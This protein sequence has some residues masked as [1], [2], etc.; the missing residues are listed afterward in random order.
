MERGALTESLSETLALFDESGEPRTTTELA[1]ELDLGRR[2]TYDRLERLVDRGRLRTKKVGANARVWW[3]GRN[4]AGFAEPD[5]PLAAESLID[6]VLDG[7]AVGIFVLDENFDVAW[8]NE[9]T[10]RYFGLDRSNVI[11]RDKRTLVEDTIA[12]A[13]EDGDAFAD[14]VLATY[15][16]NVDTEHF[17]C[18]VEG[19]GE[20]AER[21][22]E[23]RS[24]PIESGA[25]AGGRVELYYD[26][27]ERVESERSHR[28]DREEFE[29][30]VDAVDEY[31]IYTM[32]PDG[33]IRTWNP[34]IRRIKGYEAEEVVGE[35]FSMF[36]TEPDREGRVPERNLAMAARNGSY[37]ETG[38][39]VRAD[40][41][42]FWADVTITPIRTEDGDLEGF[43]KVTRD[44]TDYRERE[45][46]LRGERDFNRQILET[47]PASI[48]VLDGEGDVVV[49]NDRF[50]EQ[51]GVTDPAAELSIGDL[52]IYDENGDFVPPAERPYRTVF[53][54]GETTTNWKCRVE[55]PDGTDMWVRLNVAPISSDGTIDRAVVAA[56]DV[57]QMHRQERR[58][59]RQRDELEA[60]LDD[61][62]TRIDDA[63]YALDSEL[64]FVHVNEEAEQLLGRSA[65]ELVGRNVW[66]AFPA[67]ADLQIKAEYERAMAT[68]ESV[69]F[70]VYFPP[71]TSWFEV[72]AYPS[73]DGLSVYFRDVTGRKERQQELKRYETIVETMQDGVYVVDEDGRFSQVNDAYTEMVGRP[74]A[75]LLGS[76]VSSVIDDDSILERAQQLQAELERGE[77]SEASLEAELVGADGD[78]IVGEATFA[79]AETESGTERIGV[80]RDVT[81]RRERERELER[82][83]TI[84]ETISD[85]VYALDADERFVMANDA[86]LEMTGYDR[87]ELMGRHASVVHS[88]AINETAANQ[89]SNVASDEQDGAV[90]EFELVTCDGE[91][92]PVESRFGPYQ[93]SSEEY[94]RC[95]VVRDISAR[96][97]YER[98]LEDAKAQLEA[99]TEAGAVG[100]FEWSIQ[101]DVLVAGPSLA[102]TFGI[103]PAAAREG[104]SIDRFMERIHPDD[105]ERVERAIQEAIDERGSYEEEYRAEGAD[106]EFRWVIARG[107]VECDEDGTPVTFPGALTDITQRKRAELELERQRERLAAV[108]NLNKVVRRITDAV[109]EQSTREEIERTVCERLAES[110][111]YLF[112]W[113]GE[114]DGGSDTLQLRTE[115]GVEGYL[116]DVTITVDPD[117]ERSQGPTGR[118][119]LTGEMQVTQNVQA[120]ERYDPW[121][122]D[123]EQYGFASSAAIPIVHDGT[124][125]GVLNVYA[126]RPNAFAGEEGE[127]MA[128]LGEIV[129]HAIAAAERKR[130]LMSDELVEVDFH[131][132][133]ILDTFGVEMD[134]DHRISLDHSVPLGDDEFLVYGSVSEGAVDTL[135]AIAASLDHWDEVTVHATGDPR[136]FELRMSDPP[137][138]STVA[139]LGGYVDGAALE[140][141]AL[142]LRV[143][144]APSVDVRQVIDAVTDT[145][146]SA[147]MR[148]RRQITRPADDPQRLQRRLVSDLTDRQRATLEAAYHAGFFEWPRNASGE[149]V[150]ESLGVASPTFH[151]HLRKAEGKVFDALLDPEEASG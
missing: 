33:T 115:A 77:R 55:L 81:E 6:D 32:D 131:R 3:R 7:V 58:L 132:D 44:M 45:R 19:D 147:E 2:S 60:E 52:T 43:A 29:S 93:Y 23:H 92:L 62:F 21:W 39:R 140:D 66:N 129:G 8:I 98:Y 57:T 13:I 141:G 78:R 12:S 106:G 72:N 128:Q 54:T 108:N 116:D 107:E 61:V 80:V 73:P 146:P 24:K 68:Q 47:A 84:V 144:L 35:R 63:F 83:E 38:W 37:E 26:V 103:D 135:E 70:E 150:A 133:R 53:E 50:R 79:L 59:E 42:R 90:L 34:G 117:D 105:R 40:G 137:V 88:D 56:Q 75:E 100:T 46:Q 101:D 136:H 74:R 4:E 85:G 51:L 10:E 41:T 48:F 16:D 76:H 11:G 67:A 126:E 28:A 1:A 82:Y 31:A 102:K 120:D 127:V 114:V 139:S 14:T 17:E 65:E 138:L 142:D 64:R 96:K 123:V 20:R 151:Q 71:L 119:L 27:T 99:A 134:A 149:E 49:A 87:A 113:I 109:I 111:S 145:Y 30:L 15:D 121:R 18:H 22:L 86:F 148:R 69:A 143:H 110:D 122:E 94:G 25:Y 125:Y 91:T 5:W 97:E 9:T 130:A 95:G 124:T 89:A 118:A 36:Y 112:A 104:I